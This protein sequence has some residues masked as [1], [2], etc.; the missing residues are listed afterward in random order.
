MYTNRYTQNSVGSTTTSPAPQANVINTTN[1]QIFDAF[2]KAKYDNCIT[3]FNKAQAGSVPLTEESCKCFIKACF[4]TKQ[5]EA[6][7]QLFKAQVLQGVIKTQATFQLV[8]NQLISKNQAKTAADCF[9]LCVNNKINPTSDDYQTLIKGLVE[10]ANVQGNVMLAQGIFTQLLAKKFKPSTDT[11][12]KMIAGLMKANAVVQAASLYNQCLASKYIKPEVKFAVPL[13]I[14]LFQQNST[15]QEAVKMVKPFVDDTKTDL[16]PRSYHAIMDGLFKCGKTAEAY[17]LHQ[18]YKI[19]A[20]ET[21]SRMFDLH[22]LGHAAAFFC[23]D[24]ICKKLQPNEAAT[25][26]TGKGLHSQ[27]NPMFELR[28]VIINR[29]TVTPHLRCTVDSSNSGRLMI[30]HTG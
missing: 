19:A 26:I 21:S 23:V 20:N 14:Q 18:K 28:N 30:K 6:G 4:S 13:A 9:T 10:Q 15:E 12:N 2:S 25:F 17:K 7:V 22:G 1:A 8:M 5:A 11:C 3:L 16:E 29:L 27:N 24:D